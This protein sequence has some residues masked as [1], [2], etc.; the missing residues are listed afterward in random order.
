[1][2]IYTFFVKT[3]TIV[4]DPSVR[5]VVPAQLGSTATC[6]SVHL[7]ISICSVR[8][9]QVRRFKNDVVFKFLGV[10]TVYFLLL[11]LV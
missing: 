6:V 8:Q 4:K 2:Y 10:Y 1:M 11:L 5:T 9:L 7:V 3:R